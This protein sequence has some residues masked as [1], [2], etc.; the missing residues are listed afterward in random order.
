MYNLKFVQ[1]NNN[2]K[3][4]LK[5]SFTS[6]ICYC[7]NSKVV[8]CGLYLMLSIMLCIV[9]DVCRCCC[10]HVRNVVVC[11]ILLLSTLLCS[12]CVQYTHTCCCQ[13]C[14]R[15][16]VQS[17]PRQPWCPAPWPRPAPP[18]SWRG[19]RC[20][21]TAP[22]PSLRSPCELPGG[23]GCPCTAKT[24]TLCKDDFKSRRWY[25]WKSEVNQRA[26]S[27]WPGSTPAGLITGTM[28]YEIKRP[29][30]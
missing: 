8:C 16:D 30:R 18:S 3:R 25:K 9:Y 4:K 21:R 20:C 23:T 24:T 26:I 17:R 10:Q 12:V 28:L 11:N 2:M 29:I 19:P 15:R 1:G 13:W 5:C 6:Q 14:L 7:Q 22:P 27:F